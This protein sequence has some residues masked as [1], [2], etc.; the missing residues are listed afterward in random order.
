[1]YELKDESAKISFSKLVSSG[2]HS[3][4]FKDLENETT[5]R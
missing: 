3:L 1:M 2:A 5:K 4:K